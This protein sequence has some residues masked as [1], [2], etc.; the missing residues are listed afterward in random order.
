[1]TLDPL[2]WRIPGRRRGR[3]SQR[4]TYARLAVYAEARI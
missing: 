1:M 2:E 4:E 3:Q